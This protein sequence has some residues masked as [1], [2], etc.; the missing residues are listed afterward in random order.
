MSA[1]YATE[2]AKEDREELLD[3]QPVVPGHT[4][5]LNIVPGSIFVC[6]V[7]MHSGAVNR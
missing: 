4:N 1:E 5:F 6:N 3:R 2:L 7:M